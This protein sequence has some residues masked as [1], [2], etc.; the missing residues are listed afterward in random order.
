M[1]PSCC[2]IPSVS[3]RIRL[4]AIFPSVNRS[5]VHAA[6]VTLFPVGGNS[7]KQTLVGPLPG[8]S[9]PD[10]VVVR[11]LFLDCPSHIGERRDPT[12]QPL[13]ESLPAWTHPRWRVV[14]DVVG[15]EDLVQNGH[16]VSGQDL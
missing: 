8:G 5:M 16:V 4:S 13:P 11:Y 14:L 1:T 6:T 7:E 9:A 15:V 12:G 3:M 2:I 10:A